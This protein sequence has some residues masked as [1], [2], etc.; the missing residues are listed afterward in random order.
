MSVNIV[1]NDSIPAQTIKPLPVGANSIYEAG[2]ITAENKAALHNNLIGGIKRYKKRNN[3]RYKGGAIAAQA[4]APAAQAVVLAPVAPSHATGGTQNSY[5]QIAELGVNVQNA[6][7][8]DATKSQA[9]VA[10]ISTEQNK[11]YNGK[12]GSSI[13]WGCFSGGNKSKCNKSKRY[14]RKHRKTCKNRRT[15]KHRKSGKNRKTCKH[16]KRRRY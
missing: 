9:Q 14:K 3:L 10:S 13:K 11:I 1:K 8:F 5:N 6:G 2:R 7:V 4:A 15:F 12:G 16:M